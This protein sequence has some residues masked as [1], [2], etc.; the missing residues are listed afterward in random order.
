MKL[1]CAGGKRKRKHWNYSLTVS[2][3]SLA[4]APSHPAAAGGEARG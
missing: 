1:S 4:G 2:L 3:F